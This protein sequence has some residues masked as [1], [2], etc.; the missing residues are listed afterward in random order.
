MSDRW[1]HTTCVSYPKIQV[2]PPIN[3]RLDTPNLVTNQRF[4][5]PPT[6]RSNYYIYNCFSKNP[7][8]TKKKTKV[9]FYSSNCGVIRIVQ[10]FIFSKV[11]LEF[12]YT[13]VPLKVNQLLEGGFS[14]TFLGFISGYQQKN[15]WNVPGMELEL[16]TIKIYEKKSIVN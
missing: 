11:T 12:Q 9:F 1:F 6:Q 13:S 16:F 2:L 7:P 8:P 15:P 3:H 10:G 4:Q 5:V 14:N